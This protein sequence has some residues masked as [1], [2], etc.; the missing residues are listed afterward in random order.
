MKKSD[1]ISFVMVLILTSLLSGIEAITPIGKWK[2]IYLLAIPLA[3]LILST[4]PIRVIRVSYGFIFLLLFYGVSTVPIFWQD[5]DSMYVLRRSLQAVTL[6][7]FGLSLCNIDIAAL[8]RSNFHLALLIVSFIMGYNIIWHISHG[9][10]TAWKRLGDPKAAF[11]FLPMLLGAGIVM[12]TVPNTRKFIILWAVLC[13]I[14]LLSGERKAFVSFLLLSFV[15]YF[16]V[17][18]FAAPAIVT[19]LIILVAAPLDELT[20]RFISK[21]VGSILA[22]ADP[23]NQIWYILDGG[24]PASISDAARQFSD[25]M[26]WS[27]FDHSPIFGVGMDGTLRAHE[28]LLANYPSYLRTAVHNEFLRVLAEHGLFGFC[29]FI[30]PICRSILLSVYDAVW[31]YEKFRDHFY[32][33]LLFIIFIPSFTYMWSEG[34]GTE[35]LALVAIITLLPDLLPQLVLRSRTGLMERIVE[36]SQSSKT[37]PL[38]RPRKRFGPP[39]TSYS[40]PS[41][42]SN[43][44]ST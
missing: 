9:Y 1:F 17:S 23:R 8:K 29:F 24:I 27:L 42:H 44:S 26:A 4:T 18:T 28:S 35:M 6:C 2:I 34:S 30:L 13:I 19:C 32:T 16:R 20:G 38:R 22:D 11:L 21:Q 41:T 5:N 37:M 7:C 33:R 14:I 3:A 36:G 39:L 15:I 10:Y 31:F 40:M 12:R 25:R 43:A